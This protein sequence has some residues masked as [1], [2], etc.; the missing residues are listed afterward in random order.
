MKQKIKN[1]FKKSSKKTLGKLGLFLVFGMIIM[2]VNF[3]LGADGQTKLPWY[4]FSTP[5]SEGGEMMLEAEQNGGV[6]EV[7]KDL[8][9]AVAAKPFKIALNGV[10]D[11]LAYLII[12][13]AGPILDAVL[14]QGFVSNFLNLEAIY[15][16]WVIV[17]DLLNM[18]FMMLLLF[19]AFATIF[20]VEKYHLRKVIIMLIVMALLVN[21]SFPITLF[22]IDFSNSAMYFLIETTFSSGLSK[23]VKLVDVTNFGEALKNSYGISSDMSTIFMGVILNFLVLITLLAIGLIL[24]I[25]ILAFVILLIVSPAGFVFAFFPDTKSVAN[26]WWSALFKYAFLGPVMTFFLYLAILIF[27]RNLP[28]GD[29]ASSSLSYFKFIVPIIFLW[30]GL[31]ASQKFGGRGSEMAMGIAKKTGNKIKGYG[32]TLAWGG[33]KSTGIPGAFKTRYADIKGS[34]DKSREN[35][36]AWLANKIGSKSAMSDLERKRYEEDAK[37]MKN[38]SNEDL[39]EKAKTGNIAAADELLNRKSLKQEI[40][41]EAIKNSKDDKRN[42]DLTGKYKGANKETRIDIVASI[43]ARK[44]SQDEKK[45]T[46]MMAA[47]GLSRDKAVEKILEDD[48]KSRLTKLNYTDFAK[49]DF[50]KIYSDVAKKISPSSSRLDQVEGAAIQ[51]ALHDAFR[52]LDNL[53]KDEVVKNLSKNQNAVLHANGVI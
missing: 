51:D 36:E 46:N 3:C 5:E 37:K 32:Q 29:N 34:F 6:E 50:E 43:D 47:S 44:N 45:I 21:F 20:Q 23:S 25:R 53:A 16:G 8:A 35:R 9:L 49:Q 28:I 19:S 31:I 4:Y 39:E 40:F 52:G 15:K 17:R 1:I 13:V 30:M 33:I 7:A 38:F 14:N 42:A 12:H 11:I 26:D 48:I 27:D 18:F 24:L 22:V 10:G 2:G 41:E